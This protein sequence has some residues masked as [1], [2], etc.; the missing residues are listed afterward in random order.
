VD[1]PCPAWEFWARL[2][3]R[4]PGFGR[5]A[6]FRADPLR[7]GWHSFTLTLRGGGLGAELARRGGTEVAPSALVALAGSPWR[8][9]LLRIDQPHF[10]GQP[11]GTEVIWGYALRPDRPGR[12][13]AVPMTAATGPQILDEIAGFLGLDGADRARVFGQA[14]VIGCR[15]PLVTSQFLPRRQGDRAATRPEGAANYACMGQ[16]VELPDDTVFTVEYSVRSAWAAVAA[17]NP[18]GPAPPPVLRPDRDPALI[19]RAL[20]YALWGGADHA[21]S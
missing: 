15:L 18:G 20:G 3:A 2:A 21:V 7:A 14:T 17:L 11:D 10:R 1:A 6:A 19:A 13:A 4:A 16:F 12:H 8:L 9:A 5:P